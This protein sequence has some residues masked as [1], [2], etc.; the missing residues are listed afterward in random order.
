MNKKDRQIHFFLQLF[1]LIT[2]LYILGFNVWKMNTGSWEGVFEF[3]NESV[4]IFTLSAGFVTGMLSVLGSVFL[5]L[6]A[7][8]AHSF[9]LLVVG[10]LFT[11]NLIEVGE[12]IYSTPYHAIPMVFVLF[13]VMQCIPFLI[14]RTHRQV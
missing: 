9:C 14:R 8:W 12:V 3:Y 4:P 7:P 5:W 10:L 1:L 2:G 6:R 11:Y 13:V